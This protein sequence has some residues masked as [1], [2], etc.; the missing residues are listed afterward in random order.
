MNG[1]DFDQDIASHNVMCSLRRVTLIG[2]DAEKGAVELDS[3]SH[4]VA[5]VVG[6]LSKS[7]V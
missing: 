1:L 6:S 5:L 7:R 4:R 3:T 2:N